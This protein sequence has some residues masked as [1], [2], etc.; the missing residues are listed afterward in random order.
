MF[1]ENKFKLIDTQPVDMFPHTPHIE[2][3]ATLRIS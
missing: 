3:I 2:C 1:Q